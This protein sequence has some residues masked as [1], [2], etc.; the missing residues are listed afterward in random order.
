MNQQVVEYLQQ[1]KDNYTQNSLVEQLQNAGYEQSEI[2]EA[3]NYVYNDVIVNQTQQ[4]PIP[5]KEKSS[6][7]KIVLIVI[8]AIVVLGLVLVVSM[9]MIVSRSLGSARDKAEEASIKS[10]VFS[11]VPA[12]ILCMDDRKDINDIIEGGEIC[13]SDGKYIWPKLDEPGEWGQVVDG[14][15]SDGTFEYTASYGSGAVA[16]TETGCAILINKSVK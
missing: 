6:T 4:A 16:C 8:G 11:T 5:Q 14:D 9:S 7:L 10:T 3:A 12:A 1:N 13:D 2:I 15:V